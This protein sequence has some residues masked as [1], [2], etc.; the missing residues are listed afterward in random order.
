MGNNGDSSRSALSSVRKLPREAN[1]NL[2]PAQIEA[3]A[4]SAAGNEWGRREPAARFHRLQLSFTVQKTLGTFI[5]KITAEHHPLS[6]CL[7]TVFFVYNMK[8]CPARS[9]SRRATTHSGK[10]DAQAVD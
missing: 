6:V 3:S 8:K 9:H 2:S 1:R 7:S 5:S 10:G 4:L